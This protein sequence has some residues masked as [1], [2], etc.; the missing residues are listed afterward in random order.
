MKAIL[1]WLPVERELIDRLRNKPTLRNI[2]KEIKEDI[3]GKPFL[4]TQDIKVGD[5]VDLMKVDGEIDFLKKKFK[6]PKC[7]KDGYVDLWN[8]AT[9]HVN[10]FYKILGSPSPRAIE[11]MNLVDGQEYEIK[12]RSMMIKGYIMPWMGKD[13]EQIFEIKCPHCNMFM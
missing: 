8:I 10:N 4:V 6:L 1:K 5:E 9:V 12:E 13:L 7:D 11:N 3:F 2:T